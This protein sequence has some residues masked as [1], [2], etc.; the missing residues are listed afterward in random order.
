MD[1]KVDAARAL[2][3]GV[4]MWTSA[5]GTSGSAQ[6]ATC[7]TE[8]VLRF[9]SNV[10][11]YMAHLNRSLALADTA[12]NGVRTPTLRR[13]SASADEGHANGVDAV[14][15]G[16][17]G[18]EEP[19][20]PRRSLATGTP[21]ATTPRLELTS[22]QLLQRYKDALGRNPISAL[23]VPVGFEAYPVVSRRALS[24]CCHPHELDELLRLHSMSPDETEQ[25]RCAPLPTRRTSASERR[26]R[27]RALL[28]RTRAE[29]GCPTGS[30]RAHQGARPSGV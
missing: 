13:L 15:A 2:N 10:W 25:C 27:G 17:E 24:A 8:P 18:T 14:G 12:T 7:E 4:G 26:A 1:S 29:T 21:G 9:A 23:A 11:L 5:V 6:M 20:T 19:R 3:D 22:E 28:T 16:D 30:M